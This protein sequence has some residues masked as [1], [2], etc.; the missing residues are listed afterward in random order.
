[1]YRVHSVESFNSVSVLWTLYYFLPIPHIKEREPDNDRDRNDRHQQEQFE[2]QLLILEV[3][4]EPEHE[5]RLGGGDHKIGEHAP[6]THAQLRRLDRQSRQTEQGD[7]DEDE[8][9]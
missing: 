9:L 1:M 8:G 5:T 4:K 3:H 2:H 7:P 6:R